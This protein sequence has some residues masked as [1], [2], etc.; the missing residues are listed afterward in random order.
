MLTVV[1]IEDEKIAIEKLKNTLF[2]IAPDIIFAAIIT[3]VKEGIF[4]FLDLTKTRFD[5]L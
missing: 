5:L 3:S 4:I 2:E 1:I